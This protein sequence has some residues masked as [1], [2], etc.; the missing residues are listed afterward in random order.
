MG[1]QPRG[2]AHGAGA[3]S[4]D[5]LASRQNACHFRDLVGLVPSRPSTAHCSRRSMPGCSG[6]LGVF[7]GVLFLAGCGAYPLLAG[8]QAASVPAFPANPDC[9]PS[10]GLWRGDVRCCSATSGTGV[11]SI[12]ANAGEAKRRQCFGGQCQVDRG[13]QSHLHPTGAVLSCP[14]SAHAQGPDV[15]SRTRRG[16]ARGCE[17]ADASS[18]FFLRRSQLLRARTVRPKPSRGC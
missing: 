10:A 4:D 15:M 5:E 14:L 9:V 13:V 16:T 8:V 6:N 7:V 2:R 17:A 3:G 18:N 11:P 1:G 12:M